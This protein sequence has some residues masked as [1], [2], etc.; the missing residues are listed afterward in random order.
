MRVA[1]VLRSIGAHHPNEHKAEVDPTRSMQSRVQSPSSLVVFR[2][3]HAQPRSEIP[4]SVHA[5]SYDNLRTARSTGSKHSARSGHSPNSL[6]KS[7]Y[8]VRFPRSALAGIPDPQRDCT[9][10]SSASGKQ[11]PQHSSVFDASRLERT[12]EKRCRDPSTERD[13]LSQAPGPKKRDVAPGATPTTAPTRRGPARAQARATGPKA[14][15]WAAARRR[16]SSRRRPR[17]CTA[18]TPPRGRA[19]AAAPPRGRAA[20][21]IRHARSTVEGTPRAQAPR[22]RSGLCSVRGRQSARRPACYAA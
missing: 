16:P 8:V 18:T 7:E 5:S 19:V 4:E 12:A 9:F 22:W 1:L 15:R 20:R 3:E 2:G 13:T 14:P 6:P 17:G 10:A 11:G 21:R